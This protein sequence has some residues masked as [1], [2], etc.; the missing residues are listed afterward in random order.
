[1]SSLVE[2][3]KVGADKKLL[4]IEK[5]EKLQKSFGVY[6]QKTFHKFYSATNTDDGYNIFKDNKPHIVIM[7]LDFEGKHAIE[8]I[9]E[10]K[11]IRS[12]VVICTISEE[13]DNY[14]LLQNLDMGLA[15][16]FVK[17][18]LFPELMTALIEILPSAIIPKVPEKNEQKISQTKPSIQ[19]VIPKQISVPVPDKKPLE[20]QKEE[21]EEKE[22]KK[23]K[24]DVKMVEKKE[25]IKPQGANSKEL[26]SELIEKLI[27][28]KALVEF[29]NSYKGVVVQSY[30][31]LISYRKDY[32]EVQ[33]GLS[34]I[35]AAKYEKF[36]IL[37]T[38]DNKYIY[39]KLLQINLKNGSLKLTE[40]RFLDYKHRDKN[41]NRFKTDK[42]CKAS[43]Y[44]AKKRVEFAVDYLSF[45]SAELIVQNKELNFKKGDSFD[46]TLGFEITGPNK[47]IKEKK[48]V[49][50]FAKCEV[51]RIDEKETFNKIIVLLQVQ[52]AGETSLLRYLFQRE[53]EIMFEFKSIIHR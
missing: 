21:Q 5:D 34:Q 12:D 49:K 41:Y 17:P 53:E 39:A 42:S 4:Y 18:V 50:I 1:M 3:Q 31:D 14:E 13:T 30:G 26:C 33:V 6:L 16:M 23:I 47:M 38:E 40:P 20:V 24:E 45:K 11:E 27:E 32:F 8:F 2:L 7:D 43:I 10:I 52:K 29:F 25:E 28:T 36:I 48:F 37:R 46:L 44:L 22:K 51:L 35:V 15:K 9:D 19:K